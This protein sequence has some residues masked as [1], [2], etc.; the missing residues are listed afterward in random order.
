[1]VQS[2]AKTVNEYLKSLPL[3]RA[4]VINTVRKMIL[5]NLPKGYEENMSWGMISYEIPLK[6]YPITYNKKPL[7]TACLAAQK[8]NYTL[9]MMGLYWDKEKGEWLRNEYKK[10]KIK[11]DGGV[12]C[13]RFKKIEELP[14]DLIGKAIAKVSVKDYIK[15]YETVMKEKGRL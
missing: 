15:D 6:T 2:T 13:I 9:H 1:M 4:E 10:R 5:K 14:L 12:G 8:N 3:E 7:V 11:L